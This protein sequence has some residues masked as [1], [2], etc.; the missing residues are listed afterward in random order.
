MNPEVL[1]LSSL[2]DFATDELALRLR[3]AGT[4]SLRLNREQLGQHRLSLDPV[5]S[6]LCI[7]GPAGDHELGPG[8]RSV[9]FRQPVFLR[10]PA[11]RTLSVEDQLQRSQWQAFAH[12]LTVFEHAAWM[13]HPAA[14]YQAESKPFQLARAVHVGFSTPRSIVGNDPSAIRERFPG[15]VAVKAVDTALFQKGE[16]NLFAYTWLG[17]SSEIDQE[18]LQHAPVIAQ[19][20]LDDKVDVR[21]TVVGD[22]VFAVNV[23]VDGV[24]AK[25]DWRRAARESLTYQDVKL[26]EEIERSCVSLTQSLGLAFGAIDL[27]L[28]KDGYHFIEINPTGEWGWLSSRERPI[29]L[30]I[31]NWL[32][33]PPVPT[34]GN[35]R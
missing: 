35:D 10:T 33:E 22:A 24:G 6:R 17:C 26:P 20:A 13:N 11:S 7:T 25:G 5:S 32:M 4:S 31:A 2:Y 8:L 19:E 30:A 14:T 27:I 21:V 12:A 1:L 18:A 34:A 15:R 28:T 3:L 29:G 16:E 23:L 9:W